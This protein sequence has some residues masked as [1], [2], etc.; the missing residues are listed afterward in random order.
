MRSRLGTALCLPL[1]VLAFGVMP[2]A[3]APSSLSTPLSVIVHNYQACLTS[4][5]ASDQAILRLRFGT[6]TTPGLSADAAAA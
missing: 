6:A 1:A 5:S 2:A 4:L 3:A